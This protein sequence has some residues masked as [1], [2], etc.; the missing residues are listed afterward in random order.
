M[1]AALLL[2]FL[3]APADPFEKWEK[4]IVAIEKRLKEKPP[5]KGGVAFVGSSSIVKWNLDKSFPGKNY[6]NLGFGGSVIRD[7]THF[8]DRIILPIEPS[9]IVFYAGDNDIGAKRTPEQVLEDYQA[10]VKAVHAKLPKA[11]IHYI[12]V[13]PSIARWKLY[14]VQKV[15]NAKVKEFAAKDERLSYVDIVPAM[16]G[17]DGMPIPDLFVKDGLHMSDKGYEV[18]TGPVMKALAK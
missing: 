12:P 17:A 11:K 6:T 1:F 7:S 5:A 9:A 10:F 3:Q 4:A 8:I 13:K 18:W 16:L 14:D 2:A 15:A